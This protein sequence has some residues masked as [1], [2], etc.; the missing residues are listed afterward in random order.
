MTASQ[1]AVCFFSLIH[2]SFI[3]YCN[4]FETVTEFRSPGVMK[5]KTSCHMKG[6]KKCI[7]TTFKS[8]KSCH[9]WQIKTWCLRDAQG[10][11][12]DA[13]LLCSM[14]GTRGSLGGFEGM[15]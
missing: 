4:F 11:T 14:F 9:I 2:C 7:Y 13:W 3:L 6:K 15:F 12:H 8:M 10:Q 1:A 5:K